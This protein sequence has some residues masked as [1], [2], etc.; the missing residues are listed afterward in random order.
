MPED[1]E[2]E[3]AK[4][5]AFSYLR[6]LA[7][8]HADE[9]R[10]KKIGI[11]VFIISYGLIV[12]IFPDP[13]SFGIIDVIQGRKYYGDDI[14]SIINPH[15]IFNYG[16]SAIVE[17]I[18]LAMLY[19]FN[20]LR[21]MNA[22]K[23]SEF[24]AVKLSESIVVSIGALIFF[25]LLDIILYYIFD[26]DVTKLEWT[27][28]SLFRCTGAFVIM[29]I[30]T[31]TISKGLVHL[32]AILHINFPKKV[33][34]VIILDCLLIFGVCT[35]TLVEELHKNK[36]TYA[37]TSTNEI[38]FGH[39]LIHGAWGNRDREFLVISADEINEMPYDVVS[40]AREQDNTIVSLAVANSSGDPIILNMTF[41][42]GDWFYRMYLNNPSEGI[43][44]VYY[45]DDRISPNHLNQNIDYLILY[46]FE[47]DIMYLDT[48]TIE[49]LKS[50]DNANVIWKTHL[51]RCNGSG[52]TQTQLIFEV[53]EGRPCVDLGSER[54]FLDSPS[55]DVYTLFWQRT[56][57]L[58]YY[59]AFGHKYGS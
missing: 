7:A 2:L 18:C 58:S 19:Y 39:K 14:L 36:N 6:K 11:V 34:T 37:N 43:S 12:T 26:F 24:V 22:N 46:E 17:F 10:I 31:A 44:K 45:S 42:D 23:E 8:E 51:F 55:Q 16:A 21:N 47:D 56:F 9:S 5:E 27:K 29:L 3:E 48:S 32:F 57:L 52:I 25:L 4:R 41:N 35:A 54:E 53:L 28:S 1:P 15:L 33:Y 40:V 59:Y 50:K 13:D 49:I 20:V 30:A 38:I